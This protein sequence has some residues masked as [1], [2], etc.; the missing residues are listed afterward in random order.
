MHAHKGVT[1][2]KK[3][4]HTKDRQ[5]P[6]LESN[7]DLRHHV[8]VS[9]ISLSADALQVLSGLVC[10]SSSLDESLHVGAEYIN[11]SLFNHPIGVVGSR[12]GGE[13][14]SSQ[15]KIQGYKRQK[16]RKTDIPNM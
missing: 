1:T 13:T 7:E 4:E 15:F 9:A 11:L 2:E 16:E 12:L 10:I 14:I 5:G 8:S 6:G 3:K